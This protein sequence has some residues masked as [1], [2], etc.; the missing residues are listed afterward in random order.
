[1][2]DIARSINTGEIQLVVAMYPF[3]FIEFLPKIN[4]S[5]HIYTCILNHILSIEYSTSAKGRKTHTLSLL[6]CDYFLVN[7]DFARRHG[8]RGAPFIRRFAQQ[9]RCHMHHQWAFYSRR[10]PT[11]L[12]SNIHAYGARLG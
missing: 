11:L 4:Y 6:N 12:L 9:T 7:L 3:S 5:R 8:A 2:L 1:M 10:S